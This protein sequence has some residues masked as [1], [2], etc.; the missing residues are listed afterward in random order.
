MTEPEAKR[1]DKGFGPLFWALVGAT[2]LG[3]LGMGTV[4]PQ[5]APHIHNDLGGSDRTVGYAIGIF[6]IVALAARFISGPIA[7]RRGRKVAF[8]AGLFSCALA[9]GA[10]LLPLGIAGAYL[11]RVLQGFGEACLYTG[12]AAWAVELAGVHRSSQALGYIS[13]GIWGGISAGPVVG[14]WLGSFPRAAAMQMI[15]AAIA[16]LMLTMVP[17]R[18]VPSLNPRKGPLIPKSIWAPGF[19][20]G[21]VNVNMPVITGFLVLHL[22][23]HGGSGPA[24]FSAYAGLIL[25]SRFFLGGIPDKIHPRITY[26]FGLCA[27]AA[28]LLLLA[29]GPRPAAAIASAALLGFGFSFPWSSVVSSVLKKTPANEHGMAVGMLSAFYDL[30]V[31]MSSFAAGEVSSRFGYP[32][33]FYMAAAALIVAA[34]LGVL[35]FPRS[36]EGPSAL[37]EDEAYLEPI[38]L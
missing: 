25:L 20:I 10:Y 5:L 6:S 13:S 1:K 35:V 11:G 18:Y 15:A 38:E 37:G 32:T 7:D 9:G 34:A 4:L 23:R 19:A 26:Y 3:F 36:S 17:E 31:G 29:G 27:M 24:A 12:A 30:F 2:F 14:Q 16:C 21:F 8:V 28:G 33:A 22:A